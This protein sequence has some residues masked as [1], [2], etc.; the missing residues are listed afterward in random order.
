MGEDRFALLTN[1]EGAGGQPDGLALRKIRSTLETSK[2]HRNY[3]SL[4]ISTD[5]AVKGEAKIET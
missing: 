3:A 5:G 1:E 4:I 2:G